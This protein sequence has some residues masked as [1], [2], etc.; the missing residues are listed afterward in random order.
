MAKRTGASKA[1]RARI[2]VLND[3]VETLVGQITALNT[4]LGQARA[5]YHTEVEDQQTD[6]LEVNVDP[7]EH[8]GEPMDCGIGDPEY[9]GN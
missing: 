1:R 5:E 7:D 9:V 4:E 6:A 2:A 8:G 3:K